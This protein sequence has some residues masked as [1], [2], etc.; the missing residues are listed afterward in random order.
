MTY[1]INKTDGNVLADI[2]DGTFDTVSSSLTLIGKNVTNFGEFFNENLV[3]LLENFSSSTAPEHPTKG[4][5]WYNTTTG[6]LNVYDGTSF[7]ASGGPLISA[8]RPLNLVQGDLW[9]NNDSNQLYFY[10]GVDLI[11]AGPIYSSQ[12]GTSGFSVESIID[13]SNRLKVVA[14]L[15]VNGTLLGIFSNTAFTPALPITGFSGDIGIGFTAGT[16]IGTR[17]DVTVSKAEGLITAAGATKRADDILYNNQNGTIVGSLTIQSTT[18]IRLLGGDPGTNPTAQGDTYLKLEGG[19][20][21][22][23]NSESSR[24]IEIRTK[25][26]VGGTKPALY[27]DAVNQRIGFFNTAPTS[28][29]DIKGDLKVSGNLILQG[30]SFTIN[31]TTLQVKDKNIEL[32][33]VDAG[34]AT[35]SNANGGGITLHGTTDKTISYNYSYSSWDS[36]ENLNVAINKAFTISHTN[37]LTATTLG[38]GVINSSLKTFGNITSLNMNNGLNISENTITGRNADLILTSDTGNIDANG[39]IIKNLADLNYTTSLGTYAANKKYVD[40]RVSTRP[41]SLSV[42]ISDYDVFTQNGMDSANAKIIE[43]L[44]YTASIYDGVNNP[45]G[46]SILGTLA[47]VHA[48]HSAITVAPIQYKPVQ[49]GTQLTGT[50]TIAFSKNTVN[51]G[52]DNF[53]NFQVVEDIIEAQVIPAPSASV[54]VTRFYKRFEVKQQQDNSL[55]WKFVTDY[56]PAGT[57]AAATTYAL[58]DLVIFNSKEYICILPITGNPGNSTPAAN[59]TNWLLFGLI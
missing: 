49:V 58:H 29:V 35:D 12:Q 34:F 38:S 43:I 10:D 18:G 56:T 6:R 41:L 51:K 1:R 42:D 31:T 39:K 3:K 59:G 19:N 55:A 37:V 44:T 36:S 28:A 17:F 26:P 9:I 13:T 27:I 11:L 21:I 52:I 8:V 16:L 4:Q 5:L 54:V 47:K 24:A 23:E 53:E 50:E 15:F 40:S 57:W 46:V 32:N 33:V 45:Q 2:P 30:D 14:K 20:F 7:R 25:Q 48:S 22:I